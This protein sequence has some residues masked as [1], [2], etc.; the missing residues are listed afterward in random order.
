MDI[1]NQISGYGIADAIGMC[2][3]VIFLLAFIYANRAETINKLLFNAANLIG[4]IM[5][6]ISLWV[7]FNLAAF[8]L[9]AAWAVIALTGL[10]AALRDRR[11][12]SR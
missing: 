4:A 7:K 10:V 2:G 5:L 12:I 8:V 6:M 9:E 11:R 1:S 3:S